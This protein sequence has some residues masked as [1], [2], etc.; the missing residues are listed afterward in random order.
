MQ[1]FLSRLIPLFHC[2]D[3]LLSL[4]RDALLP[5]LALLP[6]GRSPWNST[7][8]SVWSSSLVAGGGGV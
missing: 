7:K 5:P 6:L 1:L 2:G 8:A 4:P 3:H